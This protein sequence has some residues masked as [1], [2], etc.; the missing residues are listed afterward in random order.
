M[1][2]VGK[3]SPRQI[4]FNPVNKHKNPFKQ[5]DIDVWEEQLNFDKMLIIK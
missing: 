1:D 5:D 4:G 3:N 2:M